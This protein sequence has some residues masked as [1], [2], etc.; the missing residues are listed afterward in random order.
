MQV[1]TV[2]PWRVFVS[3]RGVRI[4]KGDIPLPERRKGEREVDIK[5]DGRL[6]GDDALGLA[7]MKTNTYGGRQMH[8]VRSRRRKNA[9]RCK[10]AAAKQSKGR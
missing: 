2:E 1:P 8:A 3:P 10:V 7:M 9:T 5:I 6:S 4:R